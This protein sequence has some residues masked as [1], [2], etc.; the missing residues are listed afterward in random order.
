[1]QLENLRLE[2]KTAV[3][4]NYYKGKKQEQILVKSLLAKTYEKAIKLPDKS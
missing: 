2:I 3:I 1:M 4:Y